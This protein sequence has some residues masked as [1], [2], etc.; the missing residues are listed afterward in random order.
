MDLQTTPEFLIG[1]MRV[2][3]MR[4]ETFFHVATQP[5]A[6][7]GLDKELDLLVPQLEAAKAEA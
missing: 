1:Q 7:S 6:M 2:Q 3:T 4:E 5:M